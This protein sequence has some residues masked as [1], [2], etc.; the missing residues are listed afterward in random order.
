MGRRNP[1]P[2]GRRWRPAATAASVVP[3]PRDRFRGFGANKKVK[4]FRFRQAESAC[5]ARG[6]TNYGRMFVV[7]FRQVE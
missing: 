2:V 1:L 7:E 5:I 3:R 4:T 6:S